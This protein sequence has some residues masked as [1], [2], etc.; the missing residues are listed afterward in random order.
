MPD[1][2][3]SLIRQKLIELYLEIKIREREEVSI[4]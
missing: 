3:I 1:E 4:I 2:N